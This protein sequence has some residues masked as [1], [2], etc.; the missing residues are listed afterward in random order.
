M[1]VYN[2]L[3]DEDKEKRF[4]YGI[5]MIPFIPMANGA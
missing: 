4:T 3:A 2:S 1:H 5:L